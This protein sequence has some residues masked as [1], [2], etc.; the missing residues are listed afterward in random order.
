MPLDDM[1]GMIGTTPMPSANLP[2]QPLAEED[3]DVLD[4]MPGGSL[5]LPTRP[6]SRLEDPQRPAPFAHGAVGDMDLHDRRTNP[7]RH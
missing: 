1:L 2:V 5:G 6:D 3:D 7:H 4:R